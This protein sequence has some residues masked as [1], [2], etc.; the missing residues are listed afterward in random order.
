MKSLAVTSPAVAGGA[1]FLELISARLQTVSAPSC[2]VD[3]LPE[4]V[5]ERTYNDVGCGRSSYK[6]SA[7]SRPSVPFEPKTRT[8]MQLRVFN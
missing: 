5:G 6:A 3:T 2:F 4:G 7:T 8:A 1:S